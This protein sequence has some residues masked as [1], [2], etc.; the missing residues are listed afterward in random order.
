MKY[1]VLRERVSE[2]PYFGSQSF[3]HWDSDLNTLRR[4]VTEWQAQKKIFAL[5]RGLYTLN[6][7]DRSCVL[8][9]FGAA[10]VLCQP[11]YISLES[12]LSYYQMIPEAVG[13][14]TSVT[15][16]KTCE[17]KNHL[18]VFK[19]H[20]IK[21]DCF[22]GYV[23]KLDETNVPIM[24]A[25]PE[26]ALLDFFYFRTPSFRSFDEQL[27][28]DAFRLQNLTRIDIEKLQCYADCYRDRKS[29]V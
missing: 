23:E 20:H 29:V 1:D 28:E 13:M 3:G 14:V 5:K 9:P 21:Q 17:Y 18:G 6:E 4:Q 15:P 10:N 16:K 8:T 11:S 22:Q 19:Y 7:R 24:L 26:K 12:A 27:F 25:T 2:L